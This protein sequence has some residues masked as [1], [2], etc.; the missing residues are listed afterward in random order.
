MASYS[1]LFAGVLKTRLRIIFSMRSMH[2]MYVMNRPKLRFTKSRGRPVRAGVS[3]LRGDKDILCRHE[4]G[5]EIR[6]EVEHGD[7]ERG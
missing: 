4:D 1:K 6:D 2:C 3:V 7:E 5:G